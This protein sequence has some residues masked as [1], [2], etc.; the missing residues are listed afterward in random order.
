MFSFWPKRPPTASLD[1]PTL[2]RRQVLERL[3]SDV[4]AASPYYHDA[5]FSFLQETF[6]PVAPL[7]IDLFYPDYP[8]AIDVLP[9]SDSVD[10]REAA[11]YTTKAAWDIRQQQLALKRERLEARRCP[12][13]AIRHYDAVDTPNLKERVRVLLGL[14]PK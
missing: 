10:F 14:Y 4:F 9:L 8:L 12:Y 13:W 3:V 6:D 11:P 5:A 1:A 2:W 7:R